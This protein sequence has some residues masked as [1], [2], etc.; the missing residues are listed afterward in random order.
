[1]PPENL[2]VP[3]NRLPA[4]STEGCIAVPEIVDIRPDIHHDGYQRGRAMEEVQK[5]RVF[6]NGRSQ[7]VRIPAQYRFQTDEVYVRRDPL[8][9]AL[10]LSESPL[11][12]SLDEIY[13]QLDAAGAARFTLDRN[14]APPGDR[15]PL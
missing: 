1:V 7:A 9:G 12:P 3:S 5:A 11:A 8:T 14:S 13:A 15:E 6:R 4:A 2:S 10:T